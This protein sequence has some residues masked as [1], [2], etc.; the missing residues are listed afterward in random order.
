M[1]PG[2][3]QCRALDSRRLACEKMIP[4]FRVGRRGFVMPAGDHTTDILELEVKA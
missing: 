1:A 4:L 2:L 3:T